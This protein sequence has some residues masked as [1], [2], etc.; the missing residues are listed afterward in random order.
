MAV[1]LDVGTDNAEKEGICYRRLVK[2][3]TGQIVLSGILPVMGGRGREYRNCRMMSINTLTKG[4]CGGGSRLWLNVVRK[5]EMFRSDGLHLI[6][7]G[8]TD[9]V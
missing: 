1:L 4:M 5:Y 3:R 9:R 2:A 7:K 6:G 8:A